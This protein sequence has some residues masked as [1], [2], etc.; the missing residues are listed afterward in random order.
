MAAKKMP[1]LWEYKLMKRVGRNKRRLRKERGWDPENVA[2]KCGFGYS[3]IYSWEAGR[4]VPTLGKVVW[5]SKTT[6][7]RLSELLGKEEQPNAVDP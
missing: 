4:T 5:L 6:G 1:K 2:E 3:T 7:W